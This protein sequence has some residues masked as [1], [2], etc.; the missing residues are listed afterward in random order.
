[1]IFLS[2]AAHDCQNQKEKKDDWSSLLMEHPTW[3]ITDTNGS[4][5]VCYHWEAIPSS[6]SPTQK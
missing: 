5:D 3:L 6:P 2:T 1:M 4:D